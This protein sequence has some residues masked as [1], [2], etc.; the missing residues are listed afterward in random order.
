V[1]LSNVVLAPHIGS[2]TIQTRARMANL[3]AENALAA[4]EQR[5]MPH[6]VNPEVYRD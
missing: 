4:L 2:A 6:C 3:A 5:A 1:S